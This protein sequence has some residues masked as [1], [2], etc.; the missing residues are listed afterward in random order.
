MVTP[1]PLRSRLPAILA[2]TLVVILSTL[3]LWLTFAWQPTLTGPPAGAPQ[4][5]DLPAGGDFTLAG[6]SGPVALADYRGKVVVLYFGYTFC[7]DI[8]PTSLS[9]LAQ[10]LSALTPGELERVGSFLISVDPE[11]DTLDI[12]K[13]YAP[14]FHPSIVGVTGTVQQVAQVAGQYGARYMKQK[15]N[16]DGQYS[17]D[18]SSF[19]YVIGADGK[20]A[21]R[22]P[23][24]SPAQD[25]VEA[26]RAQLRQA[27]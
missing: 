13:V 21:A 14:F 19:T 24:G 15:P 12:L 22:L 27:T 7:P 8:C 23:H 11:R 5:A 4:R 1:N 10:A 17:V 26:I 20:L 6:A 2:V 9:T 3:L 16:A 25:I 18:H